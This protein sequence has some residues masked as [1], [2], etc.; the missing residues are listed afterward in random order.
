MTHVDAEVRRAMTQKASLIGDWNNVAAIANTFIF[1]DE[2]CTPTQP[3]FATSCRDRFL[4]PRDSCS[5]S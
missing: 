1:F 5:R 4:T 2:A 3:V